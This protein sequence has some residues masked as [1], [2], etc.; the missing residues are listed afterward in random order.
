MASWIILRD[1]FAHLRKPAQGIHG[2]IFATERI[3]HQ[4]N[5]QG[6]PLY[7]GPPRPFR[8]RRK[9]KA[10]LYTRMG[11]ESQSQ[12]PGAI[13]IEVLRFISSVSAI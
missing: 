9:T 2:G 5:E 4:K 7:K 12:R 11:K 6:G 10:R 8:E 1:S 13:A 3:N